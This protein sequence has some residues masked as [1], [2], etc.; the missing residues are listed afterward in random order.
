M[1]YDYDNAMKKS[2]LDYVLLDNNEKKRL[3]ISYVHKVTPFWGTE[4]IKSICADHPWREMVSTN[5]QTIL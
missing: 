3:G 1:V 2:I 4:P 5:K